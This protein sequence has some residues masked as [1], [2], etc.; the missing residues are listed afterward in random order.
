MNKRV[1]FILIF[2]ILLSFERKEKSFP[3]LHDFIQFRIMY[4]EYS[5]HALY[6]ALQSFYDVSIRY[7][8]L[9][10][11]LFCTVTFLHNNFVTRF[12]L[13]APK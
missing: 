10:G 9:H 5:T 6:A 2:F 11:V 12:L 7:P 1:H 8:F 3:V 13:K 4:M